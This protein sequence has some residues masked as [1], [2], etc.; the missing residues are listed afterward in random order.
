MV[1]RAKCCQEVKY[2][3]KWK[4]LS[5]LRNKN[6]GKKAV[7]VDGGMSTQAKLESI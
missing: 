4:G 5:G 3:T 7:K 2:N 1:T 6:L